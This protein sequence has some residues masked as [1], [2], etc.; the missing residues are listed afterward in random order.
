MIN[1]TYKIIGMHC[2]SCSLLIETELEDI[3]VRSHASYQKQTVDVEFDPAKTTED[4]IVT[5]VRSAGY[6]I[7]SL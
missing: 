1:K 3:G 2:T 6:D 4:D 5:A 7:A